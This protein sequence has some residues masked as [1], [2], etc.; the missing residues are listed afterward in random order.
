MMMDRNPR[1]PD[2]RG[3][4]FSPI[5]RRNV[6]F[7]PGNLS[8]L[9]PRFNQ[10]S[11]NNNRAVETKKDFSGLG[12]RSLPAQP[13]D[14]PMGIVEKYR[15]GETHAV[16][17]LYQLSQ[18]LKFQLVMKETVTPDHV[19]SLSFAFCA[20]ID[21]VKYKT[22]TGMNKKE[23]KAKAAR[24]ALEELLPS[25]ESQP[26][27]PDAAVSPPPLPVKEFPCTDF[28]PG[29]SACG[30]RSSLY[31]Q[32][33]QVVKKEFNELL[34]KYPEFNCSR[35][36]VA[37]FVIQSP[38]G[39]EVVAIGTGDTNT[40]QHAT[41]NGRL[42]H[43]SH[44]VVTARRSLLRYLYRHLLLFYSKKS[45][46][47]KKSIFQ[48]DLN[49]QLLT[50]K[51]NITI[52]LYMNQLPKGS[53]QLPPRLHFNPCSISAWEVNNQIGLHV[54]IEG[55]VFS[56]FSSPLT[57]MPTKIVS[58]SAS[59][60]ITQWQ[61]LGLQGALLSHFIEP[62]YVGSI[63]IGDASCSDV[64]GLEIAVKQRVEGITSKL[65]MYYCVYRPHIS[66][67]SAVHTTEVNSGQRALSM[68]WSKGDISVEL[69]DGLTGKT[70]EESP[71]KTGVA[72]ASRLCKTAMLSRF[73]LVAKE[74]EREDLL[75]ATSY[76]EAKMS[77]KS[78]QEAKIVLKTCLGDSGFGSWLVKSPVSD[79][80]CI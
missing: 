30:R 55:K 23:A 3:T 71:F 61:V 13:T 54:T 67:A 19:Q 33:T 79:Q 53:A 48:L 22:G 52:H 29:R 28:Y 5:L 44:A 2:S 73:N 1:F 50:L 39:Y 74:A 43:D 11:N 9:A 70:V 56:V 59:D 26:Q 51:R 62:I 77:S 72:L 27:L 69:V 60:K 58:M 46:M 35:K 36:T 10:D 7:P 76:Y 34:E 41:A 31:E 18:V 65:P 37:A 4:S 24:L 64:R 63:L 15:R 14:L 68:N 45:T 66:L 42:L 25:F 16:S 6:C 17:A 32:I 21:G 20:V 80:F 47:V 40:N 57:Q 8:R 12:A 75:H 49:S 38:T 78:Y